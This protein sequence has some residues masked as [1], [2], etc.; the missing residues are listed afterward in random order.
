MIEQNQNQMYPPPLPPS[1]NKPK[2]RRKTWL[3]AICIP[4]G[5]V[6]LYVCMSAITGDG[7]LARSN[8]FH[9]EFHGADEFPSMKETWSFGKGDT[10]VARIDISGVIMQGKQGSIFSVAKDP[11]ETAL[12]MIRTATQ[13]KDIKAIILVVDSPGGGITASDII[14]NE[15]K[16]FKKDP[17]RK[18]VAL[19]GDVAASGGYYVASAADYIIAHPTTITGSIGVLISS[20]NFKG[21]GDKYGIKSVSITSGKNKDMLNPLKDLSEEQ[22]KLLQF[23]VDEMYKRFVQV[24][25]EGRTLPEDEVMKIADGRIFTATEALKNK[26]IDRIGYWD[27]AMSET[28]K[29]LKVEAV[30]VIRYEEHFTFSTFL[31]AIQNIDI[32]LKNIQGNALRMYL[33]P[34]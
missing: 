27:D 14:Y 30:K 25:A 1:T 11:V 5:L 21:F 2:P 24:V 9:M 16:K 18:I 23:T 4:L 20:L 26:L 34:L 19:F 12:R 31:D 13:D 10:K 22:Q 7:T 33:W 3:W 32:S 29:L 6:L 8:F 28:C 15:L 17:S